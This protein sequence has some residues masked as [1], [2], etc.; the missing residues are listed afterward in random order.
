MTAKPER[1]GQNERNGEAEGGAVPK[2]ARVKPGRRRPWSMTVSREQRESAFGR[3]YRLADAPGDVCVYCGQVA[4]GVDHVPPLWRASLHRV[5]PFWL[6][7][8]C[9]PCNSVLGT[10]KPLCLVE[11]QRDLAERLDVLARRRKPS[12][13]DRLGTF[14][15][16]PAKIAAVRDRAARRVSGA[17]CR[18][19]VCRPAMAV[20]HE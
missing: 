18:C 4:G 11:R 17:V 13:L 1:D 12:R 16:F 7:P 15:T 8:C 19:P 10:A 14:E 3:L 6:Y 2:V 5:G 9:G 20:R